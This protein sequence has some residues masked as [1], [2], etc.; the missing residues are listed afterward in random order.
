MVRRSYFLAIITGLYLIMGGY[1]AVAI[2]DFARGI[3][4]FFGVLLMVFLLA[5]W[6]GGFP[7]TASQLLGDPVKVAPG[8]AK[9]TELGHAPNEIGFF[10]MKFLVNCPS[11]LQVTAPGVLILASL[12]LITSFGPWSLPQMVQK[13]YSIRSKSDVKRIML[14]AG[15]FSLFMSFGAYYSG[16]LTHLYYANGL[17]KAIFE[18]GQPNLDLLMPTFYNYTT[19]SCAGFGDFTAGIFGF[20]VQLVIVSAGIQFGDSYRYLWCFRK[21]AC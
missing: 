8:L 4:E 18:N 16:A 1:F 9:I 5:Q 11:W 3:V 15:I 12:V 7:L 20:N 13:F 14:I 17:P 10:G 19:S 2:S 6:K 21:S